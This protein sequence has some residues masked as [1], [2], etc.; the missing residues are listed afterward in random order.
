MVQIVTDAVTCTKHLHGMRKAGDDEG[1]V[2]DQKSEV[3]EVGKAVTLD[4]AATHH[5]QTQQAVAIIV[6]VPSSSYINIQLT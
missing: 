3:E 5:I 4:S 6:S 2:D 1:D